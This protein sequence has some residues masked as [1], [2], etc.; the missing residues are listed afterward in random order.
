MGGGFAEGVWSERVISGGTIPVKEGKKV[1][2]HSRGSPQQRS[3]SI[4]RLRTNFTTLKVDRE[5]LAA[6]KHF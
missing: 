2:Y 6:G 1:D 5:N 3:F 4:E